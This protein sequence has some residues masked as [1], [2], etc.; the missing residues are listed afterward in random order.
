MSPSFDR[1]QSLRLE[2]QDR[3]RPGCTFAEA[4]RTSIS[5]ARHVSA[6]RPEYLLGRDRSNRSDDYPA[7]LDE[8]RSIEGNISRKSIS[9]WPK[10]LL[11]H[12]T[13]DGNIGDDLGEGLRRFNN[14]ID[15]RER[16]LHEVLVVEPRG[17]DQAIPGSCRSP[18]VKRVYVAHGNPGSTD[19]ATCVEARTIVDMW[20][21]EKGKIDLTFVGPEKP[22]SALHRR[23]FHQPRPAMSVPASGRAARSRKCIPK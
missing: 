16:F 10:G 17:R 22:L 12:L 19:L 3:P 23:T 6:L 8:L 13:Y 18:R 20:F 5:R 14:S 15:H 21:R 4:I 7:S 9:V 1:G 2:K 11:P